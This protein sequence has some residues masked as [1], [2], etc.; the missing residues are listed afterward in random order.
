MHQVCIEGRP[1]KG[2]GIILFPE[3]ITDKRVYRAIGDSLLAEID[4]MLAGVTHN[5]CAVG[6]GNT[7]NAPQA[8]DNPTP[9]DAWIQEAV[10]RAKATVLQEAHEIRANRERQRDRNPSAHNGN[11]ND[12]GKRNGAG[13]GGIEGENITEF[14]RNCDAI[15]EMVKQGWLTQGIGSEYKW[16]QASSNRSCEV[17][18][19]TSDDEDGGTIKIFSGTMTDA[20]P[21]HKTPVQAH[22]FYLYN[23][24]GLDLHKDRDKP[25]CREYLFSIGYG[26]D[27]NGS[28]A[29]TPPRH[30]PLSKSKRRLNR[31]KQLYGRKR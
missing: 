15:A 29:Y 3:P 28:K 13:A 5:P 11:E 21:G 20:S 22:R 31:D 30:K 14:I 4:C 12:K 19:D 1:F 26:T 27:P 10:E 8:Y 25:K 17:V 2:R 24:T 6:F 16:H 9:D 7:H 18:I 23:L